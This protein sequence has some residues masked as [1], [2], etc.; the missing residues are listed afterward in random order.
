MATPQGFVE[1]FMTF[2][3][4][5]QV[6][7]LAIAVIIGAAAGKMVTAMVND[8]IMPVIAVLTP[9]G[10]WKSA[11]LEVGPVKFMVGDFVGAVIDFLIVALVI[12]LI[13][14]LIMKGD[15]SK[16]V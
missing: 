4:N 2:L 3:K 15:T 11:V 14:K 8:I 5:Y 16:K 13:V 6:I 1:E 10:D 7:G 12:F 9:G